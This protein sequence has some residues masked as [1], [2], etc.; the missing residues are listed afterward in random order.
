MARVLRPP[1]PARFVRDPAQPVAR[2]RL[3]IALGRIVDHPASRRAD[4]LFPIQK[5]AE[6]RSRLPTR[7][8]PALAALALAGWA[9]DCRRCDQRPDPEEGGEARQAGSLK[10][11]AGAV[12]RGTYLVPIAGCNDCHTPFKMGAKGPEPDMT[13]MLSGHPESL[14]MPPPPAP[15]RRRGS[16]PAPPPTPRSPAPGASAPPPT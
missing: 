6:I 5:E 10:S 7:P 13:R 16:G 9:P 12:E 2:P 15:P 11:A 3:L 1:R 14:K 8:I 4:S